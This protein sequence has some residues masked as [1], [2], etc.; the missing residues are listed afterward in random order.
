MS[1]LRTGPVVSGRTYV[2][3]EVGGRAPAALEDFTGE[4][5]FR[6][7]HGADVHDVVGVGRLLDGSARVHEKSAVGKDVRVWRVSPDGAGFTAEH[8]AP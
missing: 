2:V 6:I 3:E 1:D 4:T 7:T 8:A 5:S